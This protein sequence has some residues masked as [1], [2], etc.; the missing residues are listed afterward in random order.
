MKPRPIFVD[1]EIIYNLPEEVLDRLAVEFYYITHPNETVIMPRQTALFIE[2]KRKF[3]AIDILD[4]LRQLYKM[5]PE[6]N[7][8]IDQYKQNLWK[9]EYA[10]IV[11]NIVEKLTTLEIDF[12]TR[13]KKTYPDS[14][15]PADNRGY[16]VD[17]RQQMGNIQW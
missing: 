12:K 9:A 1:L 10:I 3:P 4:L 7:I 17:I 13:R 16:H 8:S 14:F 15:K 11:D 2:K 6:L 5:F